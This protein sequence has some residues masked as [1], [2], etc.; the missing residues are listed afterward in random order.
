MNIALPCLS[1]YIIDEIEYIITWFATLWK[2]SSWCTY[3]LLSD[4]QS[5]SLKSRLED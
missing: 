5:N 2:G 1:Q 4:W 3:D